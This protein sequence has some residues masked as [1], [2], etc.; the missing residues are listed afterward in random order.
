MALSCS[1]DFEPE[2]GAKCWLA[3]E[4]FSKMPL[5]S[6]RKRCCSCNHLLEPGSEVV[7]IARNKIP[8]TDVEV[9]IYGEDGEIPLATWYLCEKCGEI[10]LTLAEIGYEC[11]YPPDTLDAQEEYWE[12]T[13]FD[14]NKYKTAPAPVESP[15]T[16][17]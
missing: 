8:E 3:G 17:P 2:P 15:A 12:I 1:C 14:P 10:Y 16:C 7:K 5:L 6:R 9:K 11:I 4:D 13:G